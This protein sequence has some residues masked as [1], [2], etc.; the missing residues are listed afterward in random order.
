MFYS[1]GVKAEKIVTKV[2]RNIKCVKKVETY[3]DSL[4]FVKISAKSVV[5]MTVQVY[6]LTMDH[7]DEIENT[8]EISETLHQEP[9]E[10]INAILW[11]TSTTL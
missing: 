11:D 2:L 3:S 10:Q 9:R 7:D 1:K 5:I 6:M 4:T 8:Y